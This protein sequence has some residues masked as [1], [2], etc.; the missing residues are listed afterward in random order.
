MVNTLTQDNEWMP[1]EYQKGLASVIVPTYNRAHVLA[2][3]LDS[4]WSQRYRPIELIVVDDGSSDDTGQVVE[5]WQRDH[6]GDDQFELSFFRQE[7]GGAHSARNCGLAHS[8]GEYIEFLDSDDAL[9]L[10]MIAEVVVTF[11]SSGCD[12]VLVGYDKLC[13]D[14]GGPFYRYV[15]EPSTDPLTM[16]MKGTLFGNSVSI[17]RRRR[18]V[19]EIGPWDESL[20]NDADGNYLVRTILHSPR[21]AV[22][23]D[24]LFAYLVRQG[25]RLCDTKGSRE[26]WLC[27]VRKETMFSN[28]I[29]GKKDISPD[30]RGAYAEQLYQSAVFRNGEGLTEIGNAFGELA[31]GVEDAALSRRGR[32]LRRL[33]KSGRLACAGYAWGLRT[34]R[35]IKQYVSARHKTIPTCSTCGR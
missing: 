10:D 35:R 6:Q 26:S 5:A 13:H 32:M 28:G 9:Y 4:V 17:V 22:V 31:D 33:W 18:L 2:E 1:A 27:Y 34:K 8:K 29:K 15:P 14:C 24:S 16:Y 30:A 3:A 20:I 21:M 11:E 19:Q 25:P 7:N 23:R 12:F